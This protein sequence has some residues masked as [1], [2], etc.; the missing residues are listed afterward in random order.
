MRSLVT[1]EGILQIGSILLTLSTSSVY[2]KHSYPYNMM[3][4]DAVFLMI[5][6]VLVGVIVVDE[7]IKMF[8][9]ILIVLGI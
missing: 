8:K 3:G 9:G 7:Q 5:C 4:H 1:T 2:I 6:C